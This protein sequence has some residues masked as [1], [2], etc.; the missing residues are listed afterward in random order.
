[1]EDLKKDLWP[2]SLM[3][4]LSKVTEDC[5]VCDYTKPTVLKMLCRCKP[6]EHSA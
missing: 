3:A 4:F 1:M 2:I 5:V 6:V